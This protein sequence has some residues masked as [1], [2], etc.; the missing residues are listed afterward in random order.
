MALHVHFLQ[1]LAP[2]MLAELQGRLVSDVHL[3][4]GAAL[5]SPA[6]YHILIA[7]RPRREHMQASP[8]LR[9]LIVPHA[10]VA[11]ET[12]ILMAEFPYIAVYNSHHPAVPTAEMAIALL[13]AA[14]RF[15]IPADRAF[16]E[17][18]W[19]MRDQTNKAVSLDG[20]TALIL[21]Y[22]QIGQ[23]VAR[24]CHALGMAVLAMRRTVQAPAPP[25]VPVEIHLPSDL[26][27]VLP[28]ADVLIVTLPLTP[29][30]QGLIGTAELALL[31][32]GTI[33][34]NVARGPIVDEAAL[35][36][37]L[38]DGSL[39]SAG[40]DVWYNDRIDRLSRTHEPPSV[41]PFHELD[42]VV[43]SPHRAGKTVESGKRSMEQLAN[44]LNAA[45]RG[46]PIPNRVDV[47][48]G[49]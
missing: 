46:G 18:N 6:H 11:P 26:S 39:L 45:A 27:Q 28:R 7:D 23:H 29:E 10:G 17:S 3:T 30:T 19:T 12:I 4:T 16:R 2:E 49:Y 36:N 44:M 15:L 14:A 8:N 37:A 48:A 40:L 41:Y 13:L 38:R 20:K 35:Y 42:N 47:Q 34:V 22:G 32:R 9:T 33:L 31:P 21:G 5:P 25:D 43:M 1:S 24:V